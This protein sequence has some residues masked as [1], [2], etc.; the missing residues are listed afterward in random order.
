MK[1]RII[2]PG[3]TD[4]FT[5]VETLVSITILL[6]VISGVMTMTTVHMKTNFNQINHTKALKL[7]EEAV[8][9]KMREDF[10]TL[11]GEFSDYGAIESFPVYTRTV[12]I[13]N[14]DADNKNITVT[15]TWIERS[16]SGAGPI[17]LSLLRTR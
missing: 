6:F 14:I 11:A 1:K 13:T 9:R 8:E 17:T 15:V 2:K 16:R 7:A 12:T 3:K 10:D 4:G 5:F